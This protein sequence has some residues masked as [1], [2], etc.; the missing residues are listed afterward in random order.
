MVTLHSYS[1]FSVWQTTQFA[2]LHTLLH[3]LLRLYVLF[4]NHSGTMVCSYTALQQSFYH[5]HNALNYKDLIIEMPTI[6]ILSSQWERNLHDRD[7]MRIY[8]LLS[9]DH[10]YSTMIVDGTVCITGSLC[11]QKTGW[12]NVW[13]SP[14]HLVVCVQL[15]LHVYVCVCIC[16][17][18]CVVLFAEI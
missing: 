11:C 10:Y 12:L 4:D 1:M 15:C 18:V 8:P 17:W 14:P 6:F 3:I 5:I 2:I 7:F 16:P 13:R 9:S